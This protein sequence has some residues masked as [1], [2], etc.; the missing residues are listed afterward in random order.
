MLYSVKM[1]AA[2]GAA[3]EQGGRHISGAE[4]LVSVADIEQTVAAML[5]RARSHERGSADFI[6]IK[7]SKLPAESFAVASV[8]R[9]TPLVRPNTL[10]A[11]REYAAGLL[12]QADISQT[13]IRTAFDTLTN[14]RE[15]MRGALL[16]SAYSGQVIKISGRN[17]GIRVSNMD[18]QT[19]DEYE[20]WLARENIH[21]IHAREA[22]VLAS[23]VA[24]CPS[25]MAEL[26]WSDDPGY[27]IGYVADKKNY[28]RIDNLKQLGCDIG[29]RVFFVQDE[30]SLQETLEYLQHKP[31][32]IGV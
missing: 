1:R 30:C 19:K 27:T 18:A 22:I 16:V 7:V 26:C 31:V 10:T 2:Q 4:R 6:N 24:S 29:G 9:V 3:H 21:G 15:S 14:L 25:V 23:K 20:Q 13:A 12:K 11:A 5:E 8:L 17:S 28:H 32:L